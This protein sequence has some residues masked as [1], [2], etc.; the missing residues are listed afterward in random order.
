MWLE[1]GKTYPVMLEVENQRFRMVGKI[2]NGKLR[3]GC[4]TFPLKKS[5][6][7]KVTLKTDVYRLPT[8]EG[9]RLTVYSHLHRDL[10]GLSWLTDFGKQ[11]WTIQKF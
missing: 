3:V 10:I 6:R 2:E 5:K 7:S 4:Q 1:E 8:G 11:Q 9:F